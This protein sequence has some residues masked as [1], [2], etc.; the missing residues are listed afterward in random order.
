MTNEGVLSIWGGELLREPA[1]ADCPE[2][3]WS[4]VDIVRIRQPVDVLLPFRQLRLDALLER[5]LRIRA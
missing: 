3:I 1:S 2:N 4:V 5:E